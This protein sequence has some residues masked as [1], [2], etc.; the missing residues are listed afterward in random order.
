MF[1]SL[2]GTSEAGS[3]GAVDD[4]ES[5]EDVLLYNATD[6][7]RELLDEGP[8]RGIHS[9]VFNSAVSVSR[10]IKCAKFEYFN[11]KIAFRMSRDE[12]MDFLGNSRAIMTPENEIIDEETGVYY[13]GK[14]AVRFVPFIND[15]I[16]Q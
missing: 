16:E 11:H 3:A 7:I 12:A 9:L 2:F 6:E 1:D 8:R 10:R 14:S 13:D 15:M 4:E 5:E